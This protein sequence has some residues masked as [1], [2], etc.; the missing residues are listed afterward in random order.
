LRLRKPFKKTLMFTGELM[1]LELVVVGLVS[2][3]SAGKH[4]DSVHYRCGRMQTVGLAVSYY[5]WFF[6]DIRGLTNDASVEIEGG[7]GDGS[8]RNCFVACGRP[9]GKAGLGFSPA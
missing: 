6:C 5:V 3:L 9:G 4:N 1:D 8:N 7:T 2:G